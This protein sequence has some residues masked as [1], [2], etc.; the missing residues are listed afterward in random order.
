MALEQEGQAVA[1]DAMVAPTA[2]NINA[3]CTQIGLNAAFADYVLADAANAINSLRLGQV[4]YLT[5][6]PLDI[7][8]LLSVPLLRPSSIGISSANTATIKSQ[9]S[10]IG[11]LHYQGKYSNTSKGDSAME[12]NIEADKH[13]QP[14]LCDR[15]LL[16]LS[17]GYWTSQPIDNELAA[18]AISYYLILSH[19]FFSFLR[20]KF[21]S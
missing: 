2:D 3:I 11:G 5:S 18:R 12:I 4:L 17:I 13:G 10:L 6:P 1:S 21:I 19:P 8:A 15:R 14:K 7:A 9:E 20:C 16:Q